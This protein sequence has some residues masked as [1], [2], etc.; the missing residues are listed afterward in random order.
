MSLNRFGEEL[1]KEGEVISKMLDEG[2]GILFIDRN[3]PH[4]G[5]NSKVAFN[6]LQRIAPFH[7]DG[8]THFF[9]VEKNEYVNKKGDYGIKWSNLPAFTMVTPKNNYFPID[10][11]VKWGNSDDVQKMLTDHIEDFKKGRLAMPRDE[12]YERFKNKDWEITEKLSNTRVST[13]R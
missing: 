13:A 9:W 6:V 2:R 1:T 5:A 3:D 10:M 4:Y 7:T 11:S 12:Y 8:R